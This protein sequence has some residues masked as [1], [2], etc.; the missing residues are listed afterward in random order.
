MEVEKI[1]AD[2][3]QQKKVTVAV[4][5]SLT[6]G[7]IGRLITKVPGSSSYFTGGVIAYSNDLKE[8]LLGVSHETLVKFGA[9]SEQTAKEMLQGVLTLTNSDFA[10]AVTGIAGPTGATAQKPVGLVFIAV[11]KRGLISVK[12]YNFQGDRLTIQ[13][14]SAKKALALLVKFIEKNA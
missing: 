3:C 5:E 4:A 12:K 14:D 13:T 10:V 6:G 2:L 9:V 7:L 8:K 11:G 1:L